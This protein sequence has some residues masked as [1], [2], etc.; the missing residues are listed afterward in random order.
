MIRVTQIGEFIRHRSGPTQEVGGGCLTSDRNRHG[1]GLDS[2]KSGTK[3]PAAAHASSRPRHTLRERLRSRGTSDLARNTHVPRLRH[4]SS[5]R[6]AEGTSAMM[7]TGRPGGW[8]RCTL[9]A[10][11]LRSR[12]W[13]IRGLSWTHLAVHRVTDGRVPGSVAGMPVLLLTTTGRRSGKARTTPL[14]FF[15]DGS[16][17]VVIASNGGASAVPL[18]GSGASKPSTRGVCAKPLVVRDAPTVRFMFAPNVE[19]C[20]T[21]V[22]FPL[23]EPP[24]SVAPGTAECDGRLRRADPG[25]V[26]PCE[27]RRR[28]R[29]SRGSCSRSVWSAGSSLGRTRT[30]GRGRRGGQ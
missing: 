27:S 20:R 28:R 10:V 15:R 7:W 29:R 9:S 11:R 1:H 18:F 6:L 17:L 24:H 4:G 30:P 5:A 21:W 8:C 3:S 12:R 23:D 26:K 25:R 16:E 13:V 14:T 22:P 19:L 2:S